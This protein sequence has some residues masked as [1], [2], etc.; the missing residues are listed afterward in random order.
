MIVCATGFDTSFAPRFP[1]VGRGGVSLAERWSF[2][3]SSKSS[4][5]TSTLTSTPISNSNS[6]SNGTQTQTQTEIT[7]D[8]YLSCTVDNFPN[9]FI[10]L[11]P[12]AA[13]GEGSLLLLVEKEID[14]FTMCVAKM[15][16]DNV[17]AMSPTPAAV[18]R[19]AAHC[20]EYFKRTVFGERCRSWY[21]GG[22]E[23]G[24]VTALWPGKLIPFGVG[25]N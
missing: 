6:S 24:R 8:T 23:D 14:Y 11:G 2:S 18:R 9:Y 12:N 7:P 4:N 17:A 5:S 21:K 10:C 15:Q 19:F 13:L 1:L 3:S 25:L 22:K 20:Y 16:R